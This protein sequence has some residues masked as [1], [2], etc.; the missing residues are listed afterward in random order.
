MIP[1]R[2]RNDKDRFCPNQSLVKQSI[3]SLKTN[4][5]SLHLPKVHDKPFCL[6]PVNTERKKERKGMGEGMKVPL[7]RISVVVILEK[8]SNN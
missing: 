3:D 2:K 6:Y 1:E 5:T 8:N 4:H 7:A